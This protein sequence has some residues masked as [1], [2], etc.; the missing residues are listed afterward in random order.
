M[1]NPFRGYVKTK[2]KSPCQKFGNGEPLLS[3]EEADK[4]AEYAGILN[5]EFT[6]KD[7]DENGEAERLYRLVTD[8]NLN[9]RIYKTTRGLHFMFKSSSYC[10]KGVVKAIDALGFT[11]DV[12]TGKNMY[13]VL[14]SKG[15]LREIIRDFDESR[16]ITEFPKY[17]SPIRNGQKFTG[18]GDGDG[19]NAA[20]FRQSAILLKSGFTPTEVK[21][22]LG[23]INNYAFDSPLPDDEM[24]KLTRKEAL[25]NFVAVSS[26]AEDFGSPLKPKSLNDVGMAELFVSEYR[27]EIRYNPSTGWLVWNGVQWEMSEL[28]ASQ[29]YMEF[30]KRVFE[31]AK[32]DV[33]DAYQACGEDAMENGEKK[34]NTKNDDNIKEALA[35]YKFINKMCDGGKINSVMNVSKSFLEIEIKELD[36]NPFELNTPAGIIDLKTGVVYPHMSESFCT[37]M[38]KVAPDTN[39]E[40]MWS[41]CLDLVSQ[42]DENFKNYLQIVAGAIAI[43]KVY[44]E[45]LI[46]AFGDGANGKSTV[47][48]SI[49]EVLGD[50]AGKIPAEA[51]T[52]RAKNIKV[53]LAELLGKRFVLASETE[54]GQRLST[55]MLKQIAS[56]DS[57]TG[58][59]K[60]HDP[61]TFVPTH[62]TVLY[63]NHLPRVGSNDKGTWRRLVVAPFNANI[64]NPRADYGEELIEKASGAILKW[65]VNGAK[66]FIDGDFK[67]PDC[68]KVN[69]A[70]G[71]YREENDWMGAFLDECCIVGEL[72]TCGGGVLYKTYRAWAT[73]TGEYVRRN[74]DFADALRLAGFSVKRTKKGIFWGGLS[75]AANRDYGTTPE[76]DFLK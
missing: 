53:D 44:H 76:E 21:A 9:C 60:Y 45:A 49:Y 52:T 68:Q 16:A 12:R 19:R 71:K 2:D 66:K 40:Q 62:T 55:S 37:K 54:E 22:I 31:A 14:K 65:I 70:V 20:L 13:V 58:E 42:Q 34:A 30:I 59:K 75:L 57:I 1:I 50:Y 74:R 23:Y 26:A 38:T 51:L 64:V 47:F 73:E 61:F 5:G 69:D 6:V 4:L 3:V 33:H 32:K 18:M 7:V 24:K 72:E 11:F 56:V 67:L 15:V 63:T 46:I 27:S 29:K 48:N 8:L 36:S 17:L 41:E 10:T 43:G 35:Y 28:K 25:E 39:G